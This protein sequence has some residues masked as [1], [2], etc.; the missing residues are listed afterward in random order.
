MVPPWLK[1]AYQELELGVKEIPGSSHNQRIL[2]YHKFTSLDAS[3]DEVP[4]CSAFVNYC[5]RM[6]GL[7]GTHKANARS[8]LDWG[9]EL[10]EPRIGCVAVLWRSDPES[11]KGHVGFY[12]G[13]IGLQSIR[14]LGGNQKDSVSVQPFADRKV[15]QYRWPKE[16]DHELVNRNTKHH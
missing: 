8:W 1:L 5:M 6:A 11:W 14:L 4:W 10:D 16:S 13:D 12:V 9:I 2:L 15:I 7:T 3:E